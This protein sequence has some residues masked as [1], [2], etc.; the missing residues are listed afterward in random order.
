[1]PCEIPLGE[2]LPFLAPLQLLGYIHL[3]PAQ[4]DPDHGHRETDYE[5]LELLG[6]P[7]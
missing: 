6:P 2:V 7:D 3:K 4:Q 5:L 1:M